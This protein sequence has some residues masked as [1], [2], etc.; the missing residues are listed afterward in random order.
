MER[1]EAQHI[2]QPPGPPQ[3][4]PEADPEFPAV[5][6]GSIFLAFIW[7][8]V[9]SWLLFGSGADVDL[10]LGIATVLFLMMLGLPIILGKMAAAHHR[11]SHDGL[12]HFLASGVE[13]ATGRLTG[14]QAWVQVLLIPAALAFAATAIGIVKLFFG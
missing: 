9:A 6:Y 5:V 7:V 8:L 13:I 3:N 14:A 4:S 12:D 2:L 11:S 1:D 10:D